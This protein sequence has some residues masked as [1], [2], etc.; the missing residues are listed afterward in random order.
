MLWRTKLQGKQ[1]R[2]SS[3]RLE[4]RGSAKKV[5][6]D[7]TWLKERIFNFSKSRSIGQMIVASCY[8]QEGGKK[9]IEEKTINWL[10]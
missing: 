8:Q 10:T 4:K 1:T 2:S 9:K 6:F 3:N 5:T 7:S